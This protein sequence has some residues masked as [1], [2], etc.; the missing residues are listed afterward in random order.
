[1]TLVVGEF[2][3]TT[4]LANSDPSLRETTTFVPVGKA[5][6]KSVTRPALFVIPVAT[7]VPAL[8]ATTD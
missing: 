5:A 1:M 4:R 3:D 6:S 2:S 8:E 7:T